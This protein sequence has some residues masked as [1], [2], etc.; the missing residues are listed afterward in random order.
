MT[1]IIGKTLKRRLRQG[2]MRPG[3]DY[4]GNILKSFMGWK[5]Y[6]NSDFLR[7]QKVKVAFTVC[8]AILVI[9]PL[10]LPYTFFV[11]GIRSP[12]V[13]LPEASVFFSILFSLGVSIFSTTS[14]I[15]WHVH[16]L[17]L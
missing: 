13:I 4:I 11:A 2:Y 17:C 3:I 5:A 7:R 6:E 1:I 15:S 8:L 12:G 14:S 16:L 9:Q 10:V